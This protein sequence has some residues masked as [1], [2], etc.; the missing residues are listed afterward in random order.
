VSEPLD[1]KEAATLFYAGHALAYVS[2]PENPF[3]CGQWMGKRA[4]ITRMPFDEAGAEAYFTENQ[5]VLFSSEAP[6]SAPPTNIDVPYAQ[7]T[8]DLISVTMGNWTGEPTS[9]AYQWRRDGT[10]NIGT[11]S[12]QYAVTSADI[13]HTVDCIVTAT[14]ASG[15]TAAPPSN[16][17]VVAPAR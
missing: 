13:G 17:V 14:N 12:D 7:Q 9:Y 3:V 16:G 15:S 6:P 4:Y 5:A 1:P 8:V 2:D 10:T 11:D